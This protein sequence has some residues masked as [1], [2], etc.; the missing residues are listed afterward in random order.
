[1][2]HI[3]LLVQGTWCNDWPCFRVT[4]NDRV[5]FEGSI[6]NYQTLEFDVPVLEHNV[7]TLTHYNKYF[8]E[9]NRWDTRVEADVIVQDR[10]VQLHALELNGVDIVKYHR[11]RWLQH[12]T[13]GQVI[14]SMY[15]GHNTSCNI[16]FTAPVYDW[17]ITQLVKNNTYRKYNAQDLILET[18]HSDVFNYDNDSQMLDELDQLLE[19]HAH[20]FNKSS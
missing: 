4:V 20:L 3:M 8:G 14:D 6:Q 11:G 7:L 1:M 16:N 12:T 15:F 5:C 19:T 18:S 10:A 13:D 9:N 2:T 17:I